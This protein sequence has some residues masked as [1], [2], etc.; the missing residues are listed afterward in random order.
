VASE[1]VIDRGPSDGVS[2]FLTY[3][4][5]PGHSTPEILDLLERHD[6][7]A[8]F[9]M[10]GTEVERFPELARRVAAAGH[11]IGSHSLSHLDHATVAP[12]EA[13][14]DM[15]AGARAIEHVLGFE[16]AL[17]RA[18][19]G[20]FAP[21][22][23]EEA[24]RRGWTCVRWSALGFDWEE[25]ATPRSVADRVLVNLEP[26]GIVLLHDSRRAKPMDPEPVIGATAILLEEIERRGLKL[27]TVGDI[28]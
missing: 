21:A 10:V 12:A 2:V 9:F 15:L 14:A 17:Y 26:G 16:P 25:D 18:P 5:G 1:A 27:A 22:T 28:L 20:N 3:D 19:Y 24:A 11:A 8:T 4:D 6:A 13:V 7:A 23:I